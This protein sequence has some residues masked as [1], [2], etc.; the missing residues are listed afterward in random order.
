[1][2]CIFWLTSNDPVYCT[3]IKMCLLCVAEGG[4]LSFV[5]VVNPRRAC[6]ARVTVVAVSVCLSVC[7][8]VYVSVKSYLTSGASVH[9]E[10]TATYSA[11][12]E[13][14]N[15]CGV[16]SLTTPLARSSAPSLGW[17][18]IRS[19]LRITRMRLVHT[20]DLQGSLCDARTPCRKFSLHSI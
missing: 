7:L 9:R 6:A 17:P 2:Q 15:I 18:Y 4:D 5:L 20:Q 11:G 1:M 10:N 8:C 14:Q 3:C 13:G 12:N 19:A 16:F